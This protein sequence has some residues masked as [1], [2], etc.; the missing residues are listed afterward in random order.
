MLFN[1]FFPLHFGDFSVLEIP[2]NGAIPSYYLLSS[3]ALSE[4]ISMH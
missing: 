1:S 3:S 4:G 2:C